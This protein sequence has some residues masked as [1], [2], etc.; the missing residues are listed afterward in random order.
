MIIRGGSTL[1]EQY[2]KNQYFPSASRDWE[3]KLRESYYALMLEIR[4][5]K[6]EILRKYLDS[7]YM[8]N[9]LYG[10]GSALSTYFPEGRSDALSED[11]IVEIL[12][13]IH[14]P[15]LTEGT[16]EYQ[17][18]TSN[19]L[20]GKSDISEIP[21]REKRTSIN[22]FPFLTNRIKKEIRLSCA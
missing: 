10:I 18:K 4:Y 5:T 12:T 16:Q 13:R 1:T 2:I 8:G 15:N 17:R 7:V 20:Y 3:Q 21:H 14:S 19:R 9:N 11:A 6:S 22:I